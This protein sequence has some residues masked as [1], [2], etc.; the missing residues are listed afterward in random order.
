MTKTIIVS[1]WCQNNTGS[2][3]FWILFKWTQSFSGECKIIELYFLLHWPFVGSVQNWIMAFDN[4]K[5]N[6]I[7]MSFMILLQCFCMFFFF[8]KLWSIFI[9]I[10]RTRVTRV[11]KFLWLCSTE[12]CSHLDLCM[13]LHYIQ[14]SW[15]HK[16]PVYQYKAA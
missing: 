5:H 7:W 12:E 4:L 3:N 6:V 8:F 1:R 13:I 10:V 2:H 14:V 11:L 16:C 15:T 9:V